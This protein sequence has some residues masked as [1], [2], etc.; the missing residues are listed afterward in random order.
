LVLIGIVSGFYLLLSFSAILLVI[1]SALIGIKLLYD[2][3][4][5]KKEEED[6]NIGKEKEQLLNS[7]AE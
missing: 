3:F 1:I 7:Y 6:E 5:R 4:K 2:R